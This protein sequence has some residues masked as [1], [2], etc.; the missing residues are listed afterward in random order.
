MTSFI[1][2]SLILGLITGRR[3]QSNSVR[4]VPLPASTESEVLYNELRLQLLN[5]HGSYS[6]LPES[7][8][9]STKES[10]ARIYC[11]NNH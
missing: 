5:L 11:I 2:F 10:F 1:K 8:S 3:A 6:S 9:I 4:Q 7:L